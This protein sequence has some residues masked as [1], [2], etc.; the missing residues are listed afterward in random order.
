MMSVDA[1][2]PELPPLEMI[3]GTKRASTTAFAISFSKK[4]IAVAVSISPRN[5]AVSQPARFR[6]IR[7]KRDLHVRLVEG[8][9]SAEA[10][11]VSRRRCL[12]DVEHV[13]DGDDADE[14]AGGVGDRQRR[15][16]V[17]PE[18]R[19]RRLPGRRWP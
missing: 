7:A 9:R 11:D 4:P 15:A 2:E 6:I 14:H 13:V 1:C 19:D 10:L 12:G 3:S 5:S 16:V 8:L 17:L 18:G